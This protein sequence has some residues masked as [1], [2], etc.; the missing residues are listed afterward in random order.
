M[1]GSRHR[2]VGV[3]ERQQEEVRVLGV[4][5]EGGGVGVVVERRD[6]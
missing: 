4:C 3:G 5:G 6:G 1:R 2:L